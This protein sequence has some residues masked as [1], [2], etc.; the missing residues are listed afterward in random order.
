MNGK[1]TPDINWSTSTKYTLIT[2]ILFSALASAVII[3]G[4][5][6]TW[7][8]LYIPAMHPPFADMRVIQGALVSLASGLDPQINNPGDPW[9]RPMNYPIIWVSIANIFRIANNTNYLIF[10]LGGILIFVGC[11]CS[12]VY[13][14]PSLWIVATVFSGSNLLLIERGN[15]DIFVFCLIYFSVL[16]YWIWVAAI[17]IFVA[18]ALK[19]YPVF[20]IA[21]LRR[22]LPAIFVLLVV[23]AIG[24]YMDSGELVKIRAATPTGASLSYGSMSLSA[25][26][27]KAVHIDVSYY[28][29]AILHIVLAAYF[30]L[31]KK[32]T[33]ILPVR[34]RD[35]ERQRMFLAGGGVYIGT[36]MAAGNWDYRLVFLVL[37]I[38]YILTLVNVYTKYS[39]LLAIIIASNYL[40]LARYAG[41]IGIL[42]NIGSKS[43]LAVLFIALM[44]HEVSK[45]LLVKR[46]R[47]FGLW[48]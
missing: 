27:K 26:L 3:F 41:N 4:W 45:I 16:S 31:N 10:V 6:K 8:L 1:I 37:C 7:S 43:F 32:Y 47:I 17:V 13:K 48:S 25:A 39:V 35:A 21:H 18:M 36:F 28:I 11:V 33:E 2:V 19:I 38:P 46:Q 14:F 24:S 22:S 12:I 34:G 20:C 42:L 5:I 29:I 9:G 44:Y 40:V 30:I 15:N 23:F